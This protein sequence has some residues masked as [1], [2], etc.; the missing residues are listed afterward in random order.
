M[1]MDTSRSIH[2]PHYFVLRLWLAEVGD[3]TTEWRGVIE[4]AAREKRYFREWQVLVDFLRDCCA[5]AE[6]QSARAEDVP[7][8]I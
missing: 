2:R 7:P 5:E 4:N 8:P 6:Q 1:F 3:G